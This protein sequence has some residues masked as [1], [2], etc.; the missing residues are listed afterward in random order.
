MN[1]ACCEHIPLDVHHPHTAG[2]SH[3]AVEMRDDR[4]TAV[5]ADIGYLHR[6]IEK[7][8]EDFSYP[9]LITLFDRID[10]V[11]PV[12][13]S[14]LV[15]RAVER[16]LDVLIPERAEILRVMICELSRVASHLLSLGAY[17]NTGIP[18]AAAR[19]CRYFRERILRLF[20]ELCGSRCAFNYMTIGGVAYDMPDGWLTRV[21]KTSEEIYRGI[22]RIE[23]G[24]RCRTAGDI[25]KKGMIDRSRAAAWG[26]TGPVLR[27]T[28]VDYD[29]RKQDPYSAYHLFDLGVPVG[30]NGSNADRY[31]VRIQEMR[32]SIKIVRHAGAIVFA[33]EIRTKVPQFIRPVNGCCYVRTET[34][35][36]EMGLYLESDGTERPYRC[37]V[38][39]PSF[40]HCSAL[41]EFLIGCRMHEG[42]AL[43]N[44]FDLLISEIDR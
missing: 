12:F 18:G 36:G 32:E 24:F 26:L 28:G 31:E 25:H 11:A 37:K 29:I 35:R 41:Q 17:L 13:G 20:E 30:I 16:L 4:I 6:G 2:T 8:A 34:P 40:I 10:H 14:M 3:L 1:R 38:R 44:S 27:S 15:C 19:E 22:D 7:I 33:G 21:K 42:S 23:H 43:V 9:Q 39:T 5:H